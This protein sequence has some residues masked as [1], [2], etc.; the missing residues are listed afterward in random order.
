[1]A[2]AG[3][4]WSTTETLSRAASL[5][6]KKPESH[7]F[8]EVPVISYY[9]L[10]LCISLCAKGEGKAIKIFILNFIWL[11]REKKILTTSLY[12]EGNFI[13]NVAKE[14]ISFCKVP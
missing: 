10:V 14:I 2:Q 1:M 7:D 9:L 3:T 11:W 6:S 13:K 12:S 8:K 5:P 4:C